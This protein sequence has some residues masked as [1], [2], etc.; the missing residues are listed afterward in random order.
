MK[1]KFLIIILGNQFT[2]EDFLSEG[3]ALK[4]LICQLSRSLMEK[5]TFDEECEDL[6]IRYRMERQEWQ[7]YCQ[8]VN[9]PNNDLIND[10][11]RSPSCSIIPTNNTRYL[12]CPRIITTASSPSWCSN[13]TCSYSTTS[14]T[15]LSNHLKCGLSDTRSLLTTPQPNGDLNASSD[16]ET[17]IEEKNPKIIQRHC[18]FASE[19]VTTLKLKKKKQNSKK[20][21]SLRNRTTSTKERKQAANYVDA[22]FVQLG[23]ILIHQFHSTITVDNCKQNL[24][25]NILLPAITGNKP[26]KSGRNTNENVHERELKVLIWRRFVQMLVTMLTDKVRF[27]L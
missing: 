15:T 18:Q 17:D 21:F 25:S 10:S 5:G 16:N 14:T 4:Q 11:L 27:P 3:Q 24:E 12:N 23:E 6:I 1:K 7:G 8:D 19:K 9:F 22:L 13:S 26:K 20:F 2:F